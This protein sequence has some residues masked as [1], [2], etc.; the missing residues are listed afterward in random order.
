[1]YVCACVYIVC[2]CTLRVCTLCM[3]VRCVHTCVCVRVCMLCVCCVHVCTLCMYVVC[4][5][6]CCVLR[7]CAWWVCVHCVC[8]YVV[9]GLPRLPVLSSPAPPRMFQK[10][11][12]PPVWSPGFPGRSYQWPPSARHAQPHPQ[13]LSRTL[14][15]GGPSAH[16]P[17]P[18]RAAFL[19]ACR[20]LG[21]GSWLLFSSSLVS[22]S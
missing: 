1:M 20:G 2:A 17:C 5:C 8:V 4:M 22:R 11:P 18:P 13:M 7:V 12:P 15:Q 16:V 10:L 21:C 6:V 9:G 3:H 19:A 14:P